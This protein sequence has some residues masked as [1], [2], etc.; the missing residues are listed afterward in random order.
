ME[1]PRILVVTS[2]NF[3]L[4]TGGGITLTNLFRGWP[5]ARIANLHED[6]QRED[7]GVCQRFYR[8][9]GREIRL[10]W[11]F[12][13]AISNTNGTAALAPDNGRKTSVTCLLSRSIFGD[14]VPRKFVLSPSLKLWL[15]EFQ[16]QLIYSFAGSMAQIR[17]TAALTER[18]KTSLAIH[19]MD[20]WPGVI[21]K[22]GLF[23]PALRFRVMTEFRN[24][25][26]QASVR[27]AICQDMCDD[28]AVRFGQEFTAFHNAVDLSVWMDRP[29]DSWA[30]GRPFVIRYAGSILEES[31]RD[32]LAE[33]C[34]AVA[35]LRNAGHDIE[36]WVHSPTNQRAYLEELGFEGLHLADPPDPSKIVELLVSADVLVLPFNFDSRSTQYMRLSMPTKIPAYMASGT[37]VLVYG[38]AVIAPV[39]YALQERWA[40]VLPDRGVAGLKAGLQKLIASASLRESLGRRAHA[41]AAERHDAVRVRAEFQAILSNAVLNS[42]TV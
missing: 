29:R 28:Y 6:T 18:Y 37:P 20:D 1:F 31:Q 7:A 27:L 40:Y 17:I 34:V 33:I 23:G 8:L 39:R 14:G 5:A 10:M 4:T 9:T 38:P 12:P 15:D 19:V 30:G 26:K 16:P 24:L 35:A 32:A 25:L 21:Y 2:N 22:R 42:T 3:N 11:P 13:L 36:M 41:I